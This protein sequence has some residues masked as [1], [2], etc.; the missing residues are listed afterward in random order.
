MT[1]QEF[2]DAF[3]VM[4]NSLAYNS[5]FGTEHNPM[6]VSLDEYEKS[7]LLTKAQQDIVVALY[8]GEYKRATFEETEE[9]R[10]SLDAL[11]STE[12]P[13]QVTGYTGVSDNSVFYKLNDNLWW[14]TYESVELESGA[15]CGDNAVE[16]IPV[17]QDEWHK[18]KRNPFKKPNERRVVRLDNGSNIAELISAY[19][20]SKYLVRYIRKPQPIILVSLDDPNLSIDGVSDISECE[21][22][23]ALHRPILDRAV[24]LAMLRLPQR[25]TN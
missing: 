25:G 13:E 22:N 11:I 15:Y 9:L 3:D 5:Q 4:L 12:Y 2:S 18:I 14:I 20:I 19:T 10:R 1:T 24:Q 17:R 6:T 8:N 23:T 16:V 21:L 7:V